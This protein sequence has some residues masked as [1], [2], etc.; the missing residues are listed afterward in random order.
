MPNKITQFKCNKKF[1]ERNT[2]IN[3]IPFQIT[4]IMLIECS[5]SDYA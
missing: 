2:V 4:V 5:D 1:V 3:N